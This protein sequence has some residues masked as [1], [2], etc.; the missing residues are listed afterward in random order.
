MGGKFGIAENVAD[1]IEK[2]RRLGRATSTT[3]STKGLR[4]MDEI[5]VIVLSFAD[6]GPV[7]ADTVPGR[8]SGKCRP[9]GAIGLGIVHIKTGIGESQDLHVLD[10]SKK[11][12]SIGRIDRNDRMSSTGCP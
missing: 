5:D 7:L 11:G 9:V 4:M 3:L 10:R 2:L 8:Q 6:E 1:Q 12:F